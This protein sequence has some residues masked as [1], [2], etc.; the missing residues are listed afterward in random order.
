MSYSTRPTLSIITINLNNHD[1]LKRTID[2]VIEQTFIDYEW[3]VIDGGSTDGSRELI[4]QYSGHFSYWVSEPDKG[5]YNAMNKALP[6][7][8]GEWIQFLNSGDCLCERSTL[9]KVFCQSIDADI[10]YG[11]MILTDKDTQSTVTYTDNIT[12]SYF[13]DHSINHQSNFYKKELFETNRY[14]E[15]FKIVSD[16]A[17]HILFVLQGKRFKHLNQFIAFFDANGL[18]SSS[19]ELFFKERERMFEK[20]IPIHLKKDIDYIISWKFVENRK[21]LRFL[22]RI[23][24]S[25]CKAIDWLLHKIEV[26]KLRRR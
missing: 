11:N 3:I 10:L 22:K 7:V 9:E 1:G 21:S 15:T 17:L 6:H 24:V 20:Y 4:E 14:D 19:T 13:L 12:L 18:G 26:S 8:N 25:V 2:S 23:F 16:W 5:I